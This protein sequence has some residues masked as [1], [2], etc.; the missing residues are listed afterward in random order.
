M[1][2][3]IEMTTSD[4]Q[5]NMWFASSSQGVMK[6]VSSRFVDICERSELPADVANA[7]ALYGDMLYIGTD[8]GLQILDRNGKR[9]ENALTAYIGDAR[10]RSL[11][12]GTDGTMWVGAFTN[13]LGLVRLSKDGTITSFTKENGMPSDEIRC[14]SQMKDGTVIAGTNNGLAMIRG[15]SV[16]RT[17]SSG[18]VQNTVFLDVEEGSSG[19]VYIGTDGD[20]I[21]VLDGTEIRR[22]SRDDG[23]TSDVVLRIKYDDARDLYWLVTSNSVEYLK[24]GIITCVT[25]FPYTNNYDLY[26]GTNDNIWF[27]SS[28][29]IFVG[30]L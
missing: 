23:L 22:F 20:G 21:Y 1:N 30:H 13:E 28:C 14:I 9:I 26:Y 4:Y 3:G 18:D 12:A 29:G 16:I 17:V 11:A 27:I 19:E 8:K 10:I 25:T 5:G 15:D 24:D 6:L 2:S 7:A